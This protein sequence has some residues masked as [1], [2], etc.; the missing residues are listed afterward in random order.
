M[1]KL[2]FLIGILIGLLIISCSSDSDSVNI[3]E[4][5]FSSKLLK[6]VTNNEG[7][8]HKYFYNQQN[9]I[10]LITQTS[11][12]IALD[13]TYFFYNN[14][15]LARS[16]QR[17]Y[18]P[19]TGIVNTELTY[20][21]FNSSI[22]S[23]TYKVFKE[24]GTIFQDKTFEYIFLNNLIKSITFYNLNGSKSSEKIYTHDAIGN[25]TNWA[26]IWYNSDGTIQTNRQ[27]TFTE[28]DSNGLKT[29]SLL[30]WNYRIDNIPN[31]FISS[32]NCLKRTENNELYTYSFE[33]DTEGN[34]TKYTSIDEQKHITLE[35][36][37]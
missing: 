6:Q 36:Y 17:I 18:V 27:S 37:E 20:N 32:S 26:E 12:Q 1:K 24:D 9:K 3:D 4:P 7:Y 25:L 35:Y 8:W 34:V 29:Q 23:G 10:E 22:A 21:Q 19:I 33:Y 30:Y 16:L 11:N 2:N 28:W 15:V 5:N 31:F 14:D 13:S